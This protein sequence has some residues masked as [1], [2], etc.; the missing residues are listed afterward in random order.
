MTLGENI[1]DLG[2]MTIAYY[3]LQSTLEGKCVEL[4]DGFDQYQ[5][6]FMSW[7][8]VWKNNIRK[9]EAL[10]RLVIDPH[11][12]AHLRINGVVTNMIEFYQAFNV[13]PN[14]KLYKQV[15]ERANV[16]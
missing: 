3:A 5:R 9:E 13:H 1:A 10:N 14:N 15:E 8:N 4:I 12:P 16:W 7:A 6:F 2:G 11:S